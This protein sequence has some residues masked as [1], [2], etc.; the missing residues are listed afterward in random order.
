MRPAGITM[1]A[2]FLLGLAVLPF[3]PETK[4]CPL[5]EEDV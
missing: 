1:C 5:P 3:L 4:G 2:A